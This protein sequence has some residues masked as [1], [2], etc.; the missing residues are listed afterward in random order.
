MASRCRV[1]LTAPG[2]ASASIPRPRR[3]R[4]S[5]GRRADERGS[6]IVDFALISVVLLPMFFAILQVALIW[7]VRTTLTSAA[8]E[9]ARFGAAFGNTPDDARRRTVDVIDESFGRKID[10]DVTASQSS[11]GGQPIVTVTVRADVPVLAFWG[12]TVSVR[13]EGHAIKELL[14]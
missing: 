3:T 7:H 8:S 6:A 9:G 2:S 14:P 1:L 4:Q 10:D 5:T 13:V 12:P 11:S